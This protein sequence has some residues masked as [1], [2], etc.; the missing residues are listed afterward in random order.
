MTLLSLNNYSLALTVTK[1]SSCQL[2][3][4]MALKTS[5]DGIYSR[6]ALSNSRSTEVARWVPL[7]LPSFPGAALARLSPRDAATWSR[8][9][10]EGFSPVDQVATAT[11][12]LISIA[13]QISTHW[14][15]NFWSRGPAPA[16]ARPTSDGSPDLIHIWAGPRSTALGRNTELQIA[17]M[18]SAN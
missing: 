6:A 9:G 4:R 14:T 18:V 1:T 5:G 2:R 11:A 8:L 13:W 17:S 15:P 3:I 7:P 12:Q 10:S 16:S